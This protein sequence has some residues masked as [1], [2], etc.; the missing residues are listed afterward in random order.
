MRIRK[1]ILLALC[2]VIL[3]TTAGCGF[4]KIWKR[5]GNSETSNAS[6]TEP[7]PLYNDIAIPNRSKVNS[8]NTILILGNSFIGTSQIAAFLNDMLTQG[9]T[10]MTCKAI[11]RGYATVQT[12]TTDAYLMETI[13]EGGYCYVFQT[14]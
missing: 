11:S 12:Y 13:A 9:N 1:I 6:A 2:I 14:E 10:Q 8:S 7:Y 3:C 5:I 4:V